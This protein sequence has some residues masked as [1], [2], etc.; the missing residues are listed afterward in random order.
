MT[1]RNA[2]IHSKLKNAQLLAT[3]GRTAE[4]IKLLQQVC[5]GEPR[6]ADAWFMQ[7][8][9]FGNAGKFREAAGCLQRAINLRPGH[10]L[11]YF[12]LGNALLSLGQATDAVQTFSRARELDPNKPEILLALAGAY[13]GLGKL[14]D[15]SKLYRAVVNL[16]PGNPDSHA[17]LGACLFYS[18]ALEEA[19]RQYRHAIRLRQNAAYY[20]GLGATLCQQGKYS[21]AIDAHRQ[22]IQIQPGNA[23]FHSNLLLSLNYLPS[24][25]QEEILAEH[26]Q[27][28]RLH[29][30]SLTLPNSHTNSKESGRRL[31][32]GY[33]SPDFR[34]HSVAYF[35]EPLL[36]HHDNDT[37]ETFCYACTPQQDDTTKRL[38]HAA[39]HW[40]DISRLDDQQ[41]AKQIQADQ[42]DI[43][44]DVAGHTAKNRLTLFTRKPAPV[45][46]TY[47]GYPTT[48]GLSSIDYRLTDVFADP[49]GNEDCY[50]EQLIH[51]PG[52]FLCYLPP[53]NAPPVAPCPVKAN[54][55]IT[56][57]SFNNLAKINDDVVSLWA[58]V[59]HAVSNSHLVIKNPSLTDQPTAERYR[60]MFA[61]HGVA[62]ERV[63]LLGLAPTTEE[64]LDTYNRVDIALD[65]YPYNGT[66]TT[67]EALYM[68]VPVITLAGRT[69]AGRVGVSLLSCLGLNDLICATPDDYLQNAVILAEDPDRL[70]GYRTHLRDM[71]LNSLLCNGP[72]FAQKIELAYKSMWRT[73]C[74]DARYD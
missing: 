71:M 18:G 51:L 21:A 5:A 31:R 30:H 65:T 64:H 69:H 63:V 74:S 34:K 50:T 12:N 25:T 66:T 68:G 10:V 55:Y 41:A 37:V 2:R 8:T 60:S 22:A 1:K 15:A 19:S 48:T 7:G 59:L 40:H 53:P 29:E 23:R 13:V 39:S 16:D 4:A 6:N 70:S 43:L 46:L 54:G 62:A 35:L 33:V 24:E 9:I 45:Q 47:L 67:C 44:V 56:F 26:Q 38:Q 14:E 3:S 57:G 32:I 42:I 72:E 36:A 52:C 17:N 49:Q 20:D 58:D 61:R 11:S 73:W 28:A 27:W